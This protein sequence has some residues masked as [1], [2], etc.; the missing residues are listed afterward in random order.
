MKKVIK[1]K[2]QP[3]V[4]IVFVTWNG[5]GYTFDLLDSLKKIKYKNYDIIVVD[6]GSTDG[7][8][9]EFKKRYK[10]IA[11]LIE[12]KKNLGLAEGLNVGIR[13]G[14]KRNSKYILI[15]NNDM[16]VKKDFLNFLVD[17]MEK[18]PEVAVV[19]PKVYYMDPKNMIQNAGCDYHFHGFKPRRLGEIE[20]GQD[21]KE[22]YVDAI[23]C[24]LMMRDNLLKKY[25]LFDSKLFFINELTELCLRVSNK[26]Y[27][28]LYVPNSIVWHKVAAA[29]ED[30]ENENETEVSVYYNIRNWLL[31]IKK[32]KP[33]PYFL[34]I[35]FLQ[36]T[37]FALMRFIRYAKNGR[38]FLIK[39]YYIAIWHALINKTPIELYPYKK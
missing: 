28:S 25:G 16:I 34:L 18:H 8:Q 17:S 36:T 14:L 29:F 20:K 26:G 13:K 19:G 30:D 2:F 5:K 27:N 7:T 3:K 1:K 31:V 23:D 15:M 38:L 22:M 9:K 39:T 10:K 6:N 24:V 12:N 33:L 11:T 4:S 32:N 35:L 21:K 37:L